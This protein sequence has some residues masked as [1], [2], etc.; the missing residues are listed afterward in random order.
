M[1]RF[2]F[3]EIV[4]TRRLS[5]GAE[6]LGRIEGCD[7]GLWSVVDARGVIWRRKRAEIW[8]PAKTD[9]RALAFA[10]RKPREVV[11]APARAP[12]VAVHKPAG[13]SLADRVLEAL[14]ERPSTS[15]EI[16]RK[17]GVMSSEVA[18]R[19][20]RLESRR[21]CVRAGLVTG[22]RGNPIIVWRVAEGRA[23]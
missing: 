9:P 1:S 8:R 2:E 7:C 23:A 17:L 21:R 12:V 22:G 16:A 14:G 10:P 19:L 11:V 20:N 18:E 6:F 15:P 5:D 4:A 13:L 3:G